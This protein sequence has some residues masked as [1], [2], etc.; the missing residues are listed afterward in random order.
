MIVLGILGLIALILIVIYSLWLGITPMPT[1]PKVKKE[2]LALLPDKIEGTIYE[3]G[4]GWGT[5]ARPLA[6]MYQE[7]NVLAYE[8]SPIP[9]LL[10]QLLNL[11]FPK[12]N[13]RIERVDFF[14]K[15]L[16]TAGLVVCYLYPGAM[17]KLKNKFEAELKPGT[18]VISN[19][20]AVP[21]WKSVV[22]VEVNDLYRS[23]VYL[24]RV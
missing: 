9:F 19:T 7:N 11:V 23:K 12:R 20:F 13:L 2:L 22:T 4:S 6:I 8:L 17:A 15:K 21:G 14:E 18:W 16:D 3:L 5:L 1:S 24:Y 10:S